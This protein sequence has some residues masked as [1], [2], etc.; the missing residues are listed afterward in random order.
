V[1][2]NGAIVSFATR[3]FAADLVTTYGESS[4]KKFPYEYATGQDSVIHMRLNDVAGVF[5]T[6]CPSLDPEE[7]P[8]L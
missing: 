6:S 8:S 5:V 1:F 7:M 4:V 2:T 3:G